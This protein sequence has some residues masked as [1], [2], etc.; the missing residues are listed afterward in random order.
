MSQLALAKRAG[1]THNFINDIEKSKKGVSLKTI[2]IL[3]E[4][5]DAEPYQFF[6]KPAE[7]S[8]Y[9]KKEV[10]SAVEL[11]NRNVN[12]LFEKTVKEIFEQTVLKIVL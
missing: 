9:Y 7:G 6:I 2:G 5:L 4:A 1:L 11:L 8:D 3:A 12:R 10:K